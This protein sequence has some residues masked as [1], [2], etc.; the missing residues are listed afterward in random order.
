MCLPCFPFHSALN[1]FTPLLLLSTSHY[2]II[3]HS[4]LSIHYQCTYTLHPTNFIDNSTIPYHRVPYRR[5]TYEG[6]QR[7][8]RRNV[9]SS[10]LP[11]T[12]HHHYT[13][14][15]LHY[16]PTLLLSSTLLY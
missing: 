16:S 5:N 6:Q 12:P 2:T 13:S 1:S 3:F 7:I 4:L 8:R 10:L 15:L 14:S 9:L 11:L